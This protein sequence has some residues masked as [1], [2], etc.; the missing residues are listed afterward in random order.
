MSPLPD[1]AFDLHWIECSIRAR[2]SGRSGLDRV[3]DL[4][5]DRV[6]DLPAVQ[7]VE[8]LAVQV[9]ELGEFRWLN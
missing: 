2:S 4:L 9:A 3:V 1:R 6:F 8:L 5:R 7:V